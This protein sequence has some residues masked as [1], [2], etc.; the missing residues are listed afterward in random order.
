MVET[1]SS[2][3][4]QQ[5]STDDSLDAL[6]LTEAIEQA[7]RQVTQTF[8]KPAPDRDR[9][10]LAVQAVV[11]GDMTIKVSGARLPPPPPT[12]TSPPFHSLASSTGRLQE[13]AVTYQ[14]A[15]STMHPYVHRARATL[16]ER[17]P[18]VKINRPTMRR[19]PQAQ[20]SSFV[21]AQSPPPQPS[22]VAGAGGDDQAIDLSIK[23]NEAA[24]ATPVVDDDESGQLII[25]ESSGVKV[26]NHFVIS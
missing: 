9:L 20:Q 17:A 2:T 8:S 23:G 5:T 11:S 13:A 15:T 24:K 16:G 18:P 3:D 6:P 21:A 14:F 25:D 10:F 4:D 1:A 19:R 7:V 26:A 22:S 12:T